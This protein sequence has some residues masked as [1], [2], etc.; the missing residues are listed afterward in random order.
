VLAGAAILLLPLRRG[1]VPVLLLAAA[2]GV[3]VALAG[4]PLP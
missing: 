3:V 1:V 2:I 4:G